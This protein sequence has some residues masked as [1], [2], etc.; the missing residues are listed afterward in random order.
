MCYEVRGSGPYF[1]YNKDTGKDVSMISFRTLPEAEAFIEL[2]TRGKK[3]QVN[4][5]K[6]DT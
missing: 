1:I 5:S 3:G 6:K 2:L 4:D